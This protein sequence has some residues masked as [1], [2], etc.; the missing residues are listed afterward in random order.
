MSLLDRYILRCFVWAYVGC[1]LSLLCLFVVVDM[2]GKMH[3]FTEGTA[4]FKTVLTRVR[5]YYVHRLPWLF[6]RFHSVFGLLAVL[7][8]WAW[9]EK[10]NEI[11]PWFAAGVPARRLLC[12]LMVGILLSVGLSLANREVLVPGCAD[13][14]QRR[15]SDP[16]GKNGLSVRGG[17][18]GNLIH[19]EGETA[20]A[21][22]RVIQ[23]GRVT[24]PAHAVGK[25]VRVGCAEMLYRPAGPGGDSGWYLMAAQPERIDAQHPSLDWL[26]PNTYFLHTD[27]SFDQ[28]TRAGNW[29]RYQPTHRLLALAGEEEGQTN[30]TAMTALLHR[31]LTT[32][33]LDVL[34]ALIGIGL[35][36]GRADRCVVRRIGIG[37]VVYFVF[38]ASLMACGYLAESGSLSPA[39]AAWLP[40]FVYGPTAFVLLDQVRS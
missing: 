31:R 15:A 35:V 3:E 34:L 16:F 5:I 25:I 30:R 19:F 9:M 32:P 7:F 27:M 22:R 14:L 37:L 10:Q 29:Y 17:F 13:A 24:L 18:D 28:L 1:L 21:D 20:Y 4:K 36:A 33:L 12:P 23:Q 26:G 38:E 40:V 2:F 6:D 8:T 39:L 11:T